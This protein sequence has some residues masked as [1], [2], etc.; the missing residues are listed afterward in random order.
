MHGSPLVL[1]S[2]Q[3]SFSA[4]LKLRHPKWSLERNRQIFGKSVGSH[5]ADFHL[6]IALRGAV[7][8]E[9]G[10]IVNIIE[11]K[12]RLAEVVAQLEDKFLDEDIS[13]F[14]DNRPT[15][16]NIT[17]FLWDA[18][19]SHIGTGVLHRLQLDQ[20]GRTRVEM[21]ADSIS[22]KVSR[23]YEFAAAH[24]LF[25][26]AL[27]EQ[28]N[29]RRFDKCSNAAGHGHN[30]QLQVWIEGTPDDETGFIINPS[31]LDS[32]VETEVYQ[33]FDHKHLN[34][35]CP[36]FIDAALVPTSENLAL[37]IFN[38]LRTRLADEGYRLVRVGL[39]ETQKN[40]FEVEA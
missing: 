33:R 11:V 32:I 15:A 6:R 18:M 8:P 38:L 39:Q 26:P 30:F 4:G 14:R 10:M 19:P 27:S 16:E 31:L 28:E 23:S 21:F 40:Y 7:S 9:D 24:R 34:E 36:E 29:W 25:A 13:F 1:L 3:I 35:D 22:M 2:R 37:V 5:G 20:S 17:R 12:P